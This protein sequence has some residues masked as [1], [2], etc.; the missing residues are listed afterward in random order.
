MYKSTEREHEKNWKKENINWNIKDKHKWKTSDFS[1]FLTFSWSWLQKETEK[2]QRKA[3]KTRCQLKEFSKS[4]ECNRFKIG[5][6]PFVEVFFLPLANDLL[7]EW[8]HKCENGK[9][10]K[11]KAKKGKGMKKKT[12]QTESKSRKIFGLNHRSFTASRVRF[13]TLRVSE[14]C[15]ALA[16][17]KKINY[18]INR[19]LP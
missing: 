6:I 13:V 8:F 16:K 4:I 3:E 11:E 10:N 17:K 7:F 5:K 15:D 14:R 12:L 18:Q 19:I 1:V 9:T 2:I